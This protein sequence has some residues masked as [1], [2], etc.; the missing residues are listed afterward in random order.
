MNKEF[1]NY[2][3]TFEKAHVRLTDVLGQKKDE[4]MRDSA[5]QRFEF[6]FELFWKLL[7]KYCEYQGKPVNS[8]RE[9]IREVFALQVID[10]DLRYLEMLEH[11]NMTTHTYREDLAEEIYANLPIYANLMQ[12]AMIEIKNQLKNE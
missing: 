3:N 4:Y 6:T 12:K 5:I 10:E 8:P 1:E 11:R 2:F 7:K 9:S